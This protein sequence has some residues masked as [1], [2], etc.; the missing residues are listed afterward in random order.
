MGGRDPKAACVENEQ[1]FTGG[2][3]PESNVNEGEFLFGL[4]HFVLF[5]LRK[6]FE[7]RVVNLNI[8]PLFSVQKTSALQILWK[9]PVCPPHPKKEGKLYC[10]L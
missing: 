4:L 1:K 9:H 10:T 3:W 6:Y 8:L 5:L 7:H 2:L